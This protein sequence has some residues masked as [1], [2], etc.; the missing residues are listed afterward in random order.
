MKKNI[1][2]LIILLVTFSLNFTILQDHVLIEL[3]ASLIM[4]LGISA[5]W[6]LWK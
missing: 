3:G 1:L 6:R 2:P 4:F 5:Y